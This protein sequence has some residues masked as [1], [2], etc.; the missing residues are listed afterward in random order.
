[1]SKF[2][3]SKKTK[4]IVFTVI[5]ILLVAGLAGVLIG[6][7]SNPQKDVNPNFDRGKLDAN[8]AYVESDVTL[9]T[10]GAIE[11]QGLKVAFDF[12]HNGEYQIFWYNE[13]DL[14]LYSESRTD[15]PFTD[16][17]PDLAKYCRI[18]IYPVLEE[19]DEEISWYQIGKYSDNLNITVERYQEFNPENHYETAKLYATSNIELV[20]SISSNYAFIKNAKLAVEE[21]GD[22]AALS[23]FSDS[24]AVASDGYNVI[25]LDCSEV[26]AYKL[27][28]DK[29]CGGGQYHVFFYDE[30]GNA[31]DPAK[32][33]NAK[34]GGEIVINVK[35]EAKYICFNVYPADL[36]EGG[37]DIPIVINEY[38]PRS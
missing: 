5:S 34:E 6:I 24:L 18:V 1:M 25:K 30:D 8:G 23:S 16:P 33:I 27:K 35:A 12:E 11:C 7:F 31:L 22:T 3:T 37:K 17:V 29:V 32:A 38:L 4:S 13:D 26:G 36:V 28:F 9:Y 21:Y 14:F 15:K 19:G 2:R 10:P 20:E